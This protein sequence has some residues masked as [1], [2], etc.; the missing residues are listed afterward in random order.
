MTSANEPGAL[1]LPTTHVNGMSRQLLVADYE[2]ARHAVHAA[3]TAVAEACPNAR[4]YY[5]QSEEAFTS[6]AVQ[7]T[8]R[9]ESLSRIESELSAILTSLHE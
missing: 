7:H 5:R 2:I 6:A 1:T 3:I 4:E 8:A 9:L